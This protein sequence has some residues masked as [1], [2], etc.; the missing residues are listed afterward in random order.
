MGQTIDRTEEFNENDPFYGLRPTDS[1]VAT[2]NPA[3][4]ESY[5]PNDPMMPIVWTKTYQIPGGQPGTALTS[6]IGAATDMVSA[7]VRRILVNATYHLTGLEVPE[8]A[9]VDV[10]GAY[11]PSAYNFHKDEYWAQKNMKVADHILPEN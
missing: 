2:V 9:D 1:K 6:T 7:G 11:N 3:S 10:V 4:K 5:N 8:K